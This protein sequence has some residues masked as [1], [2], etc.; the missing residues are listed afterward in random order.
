M[1]YGYMMS[2]LSGV[3]VTFELAAISSSTIEEK[4]MTERNFLAM[5]R[6][7]WQ[8][9]FNL[10]VGLDIDAKKIPPDCLPDQESMSSPTKMLAYG[11]KIVIKTAEFVCAY[12][13][14][15][16]F[17]E[18]EGPA[19]LQALIELVQFIKRNAPTVPTILDAKRA[20]IG[21]TNDHY[22]R[23]CFEQYGVDAVTVH[24]YLGM[25]AMAPFLNCKDKGIIVLCRTSNP[26]AGEFQDLP[27]LLTNEQIK[28]LFPDLPTTVSETQSNAIQV[29]GGTKF[30]VPLYQYVAARVN[31]YWNTAGNCAV[32]VGATYPE[33]GKMVRQLA[34]GLTQLLPGVGTQGADVDATVLNC[35]GDE[36]TYIIINSS[37]GILFAKQKQAKKYDGVEQ[38]EAALQEALETHEKIKA[39]LAKAKRGEK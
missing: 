14:N 31:K 5:I 16:A 37:S 1:N 25:E 27:I 12:K 22:V 21:N 28:D 8:L 24:P 15:I 20:D 4:E 9:G 36:E 17:F 10:C 29:V 18:S 2:I 30:T 39:A 19:G 35:V 6:E 26:G 33:E 13:P 34:P 38:F 11:K 32:V 7:R 23:A 3:K